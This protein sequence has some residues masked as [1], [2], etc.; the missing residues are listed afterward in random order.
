M[1]AGRA[2]IILQP[3]LLK[4]ASDGSVADGD[5][6]LPEFLGDD[7]AVGIGVEESG[8]DHLP[9]DFVSS[10][11]VGFRTTFFIC[12]CDGSVLEEGLADL[13]IALRGVAEFVGR[14]LRSEPFAFAFDEHGELV[15]NFIVLGNAQG[16]IVAVEDSFF[17]VEFHDCPSLSVRI[18]RARSVVA[19]F[20]G[21]PEIRLD[22]S[23]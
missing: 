7:F 14:L 11:V 5:S 3:V 1:A 6:L 10:S 17:D 15:G 19:G 16:S 2:D 20:W 21:E 23:N 18:S 12:E 8:A 13:E 9:F 4:D 22:E